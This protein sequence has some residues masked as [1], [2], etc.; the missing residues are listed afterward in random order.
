MNKGY[1]EVAQRIRGEVSD[2]DQVAERAIQSWRQAR[3]RARDQAAF[4]DSVALNLHGLYS[5][6]ER[7]FELIA[8][9]VDGSV[10]AGEIW[11]RELLHQ[12]AA[13]RSLIRPAVIGK[14]TAEFLDELRR[15][16]HLVRH[17]YAF[18][19]VPDRLERLMGRLPEVWQQ[20]RE[21]LLAFS[22]FLLESAQDGRDEG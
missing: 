4:L 10:P 2:L 8:R 9:Q 22:A 11:H 15:F 5:G 19:L 14:E 17:V 21:E 16:R 6:T 1:Q 12:M 20:L 3:M 7:L 18:S 13:D